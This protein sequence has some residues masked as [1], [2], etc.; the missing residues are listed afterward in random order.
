MVLARLYLPNKAHKTH[1]VKR[2]PLKSFI[3][4]FILLSCLKAYSQ[5]ELQQI[6]DRH[7]EEVGQEQWD[8]VD[9]VTI[10]GRWVDEDYRGYSIDILYK[11]PNKIRIDGTYDGRKFIEVSDGQNARIMAPWKKQNTVQ[12]M[13]FMEKLILENSFSLGSPIKALQEEITFNGLV[14]YKGTVYLTLVYEVPIGKGLLKRTF[15]LDQVSYQLSLETF[16][17]GS[18]GYL[19]KVY[20]KYRN[21]GP[22]TVPIAV[23]FQADE[24]EKELVFDE[25]FIGLGIK[26]QLFLQPKGQ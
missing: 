2:I 10:D 23:I 24:I 7:F 8:Q 9:D 15:Y 14:D 5:G 6:L 11:R 17:W 1:I 19:E 4:L 20:D 21:Y 13:T 12:E 26:N 18:S 3:Q 22:L 25:I 16:E